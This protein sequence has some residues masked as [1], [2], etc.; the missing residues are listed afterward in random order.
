MCICFPLFHSYC[1]KGFSVLAHLKDHEN[2]HTNARPYKCQFCD[3]RFNAI[4]TKLR[5]E[6]FVREGK[7][8]CPRP[9]TGTGTKDPASGKKKYPVKY[10]DSPCEHCGKIFR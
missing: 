4:A 10:K 5:H 3:N 9:K 8:P 7:G 2:I 1:P 6:S